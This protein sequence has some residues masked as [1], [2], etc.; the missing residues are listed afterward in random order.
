MEEECVRVE[1]TIEAKVIKN[2]RDELNWKVAVSA[3]AASQVTET[4]IK[5]PVLHIASARYYLCGFQDF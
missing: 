1:H 3:F 2:R 5:C 4:Q